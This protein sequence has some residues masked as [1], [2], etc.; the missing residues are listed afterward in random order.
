MHIFEKIGSRRNGGGVFFFDHAVQ[1]T[2]WAGVAKI[3]VFP[4]S[5]I[6]IKLCMHGSISCFFFLSFFLQWRW[7]WVWFGVVLKTSG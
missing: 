3:E 5:D 7:E 2:P 4:Q 1:L 6:D